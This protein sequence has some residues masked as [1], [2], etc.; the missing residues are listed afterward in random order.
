MS[1]LHLDA[2]TLIHPQG[3]ACFQAD[4]DAVS[5]QTKPHTDL[6]QRTYYHF[7]NDNAPMYLWSIAEQYFSLTFKVEASGRSCRFDQCG[8]ALYIDADN[9]IKVSSEYAD[10]TIQ[11]LGCVVTDGGYS[12]WS[13]QEIPGDIEAFYFRASRRAD[14][15]KL[16]SSFDGINFQQLRICHL[17]AAT[18]AVPA[19]I[20]AAS[21]EN[22]SFRAVF[23][24]FVLSPCL[25]AAHDGQQPDD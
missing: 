22:G 17:A 19:G 9:W 4:A 16:E 25:W 15:F 12:D 1:P 2:G 14:D 23:S 6:W 5:L 8:F 24:D 21:P 11:H 3:A 10:G 18:G 20:Y 13:M 7:R